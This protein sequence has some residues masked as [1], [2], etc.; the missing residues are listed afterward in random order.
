MPEIL[1]SIREG[2]IQ[3]LAEQY[4]TA[5]FY[6]PHPV[7]PPFRQVTYEAI[8]GEPG[9]HSDFVMFKYCGDVYIRMGVSCRGEHI[10]VCWWGFLHQ[11]DAGGGLTDLALKGEKTLAYEHPQLSEQLSNTIQ[12]LIDKIEE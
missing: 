10:Y 3:Q 8:D 4:P 7:S 11:F 5:E 2:L 12:T 6:L 9:E 1:E